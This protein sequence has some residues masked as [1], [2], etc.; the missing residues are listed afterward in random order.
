MKAASLNEAG[1]HYIV[2]GGMAVIAHGYMRATHDVDIV[3]R[4]SRNNILWSDRHRETP[5]DIFVDEPA[6]QPR[7]ASIPALI[8]MKRT[9]S[10]D[11][12]LV[13]IEYLQKIAMLRNE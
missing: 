7:F 1:V 11:R 4:L 12:D 10:R 13:D 2:V 8:A 3:V 6:P 9:A 5:L